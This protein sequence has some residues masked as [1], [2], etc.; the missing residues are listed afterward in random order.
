M[1]HR[2]AIG[3]YRAVGSPSLSIWHPP[4]N[5]LHKV[6]I[7]TG[8]YTSPPVLLKTA[9][10]RFTVS[11]MWFGPTAALVLGGAQHTTYEP[12][13]W[14]TPS[15]L[16]PGMG[17]LGLGAEGEAAAPTAGALPG[18]VGFGARSFPSADSKVLF[19]GCMEASGG[20]RS[21]W[22]GVGDTG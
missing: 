20:E 9:R 21:I 18:R 13:P 6:L 5:P 11:T 3:S 7:G 16:I 19:A 12:K 22:T 4:P 2:S 17:A 15:K 8:P 1:S 14:P 10:S